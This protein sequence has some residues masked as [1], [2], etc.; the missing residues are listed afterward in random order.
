MLHVWNLRGHNG[1]I[2]Y[3]RP[4]LE[5]QLLKHNF[6]LI[7]LDPVYK[8]LGDRDEN[9]NGEIAGLMNEFE[10]MAQ[11]TGAAVVMAHHFAKGDSTSKSAMD[12]L[13]GAGAW[14][15]DPDSILILTP[16]EEDG[17]FTVSSIVRNLP[18]VPEFVV[19]WEFPLM[20]TAIDLN[21]EALRRPQRKNKVCSDKE[22]VEALLGTEPRI[23]SNVIEEAQEKLGMSRSTASRY[24]NRLSKTGVITTA[25][26][27][28]WIAE[29]N[30]AL[31]KS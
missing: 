15:R 23:F 20:K 12:R 6:R 5:E 17:C 27:F 16:H 29:K 3:L 14:A 22:F 1:D 31:G 13:S 9:A 7:I 18:N 28:Y 24:L 21:P 19:S 8:V 26:G 25:G 11:K 4:Q 10:A 30:P 2:T